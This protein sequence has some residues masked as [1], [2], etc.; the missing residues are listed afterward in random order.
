MKSTL[1]QL[2]K[3]KMA[4]QLHKLINIKEQSTDWL[5]FNYNFALSRLQIFFNHL[6]FKLQYSKQNL[7]QQ[8]TMPEQT[9]PP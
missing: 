6:S 4:I 7:K 9:N 3:Y 2:M 1:N 5:S 8:I